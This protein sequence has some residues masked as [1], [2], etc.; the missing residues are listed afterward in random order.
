[1]HDDEEPKIVF[2][3]SLCK[4]EKGAVQSWK[5]CLV[6]RRLSWHVRLA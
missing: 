3:V 4:L 5:A 1:M 6:I 2:L